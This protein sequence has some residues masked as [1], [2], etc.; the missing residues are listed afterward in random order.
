[1]EKI[2]E[3]IEKELR[4]VAEGKPLKPLKKQLGEEITVC[5]LRVALFALQW[6]SVGYHS[7]LRLAGMKLGKRV[8]TGSEKTE[9]SLVL[10]E[11]ARI[12][13]ALRGGEVET[14]IMPESRGAQIKIYDSPLLNDIPNILQNICFFEEG[15]IEGYLDGVIAKQGA[16]ALAEAKFSIS[17]VSVEEKRCVGLGDDHCGFLIKF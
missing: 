15:F 12:L 4:D 14:E 5:Y 16:L 13:R 1:M 10:E 11:I 6:T 8:G 3:G 17:E 7:A 9:L 2:I